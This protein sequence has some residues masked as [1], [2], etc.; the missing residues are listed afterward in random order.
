MSENVRHQVFISSTFSDLAEER[1]AVYQALLELDFVPAGME[2]FAATDEEQLAF[3]K[4]VIDDCD[5]YLVIVGNR[6]G[7]LTSDG[8]S[9]RKKSTGMP[10]KRYTCPRVHS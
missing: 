6:Y 2:L 7:S 8:I 9:I 5:Y 3:I 10:S 1:R 4:K